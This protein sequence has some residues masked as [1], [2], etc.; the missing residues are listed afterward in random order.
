MAETVNVGFIG[1]GGNARGHMTNVTK[2]GTGPERGSQGTKIVGVCDVVADLAQKAA[3]DFGATAYTDHRALLDRKDLH[4]VYISIP[5]F[6][7]G[8]PEM[9]TIE[10]GLPF[11]VEKPVALNLETARAIEKAVQAR[12]L[13]TCVGYQLRYTG[14]ADAAR[15]ILAGKTVSM[16]IGKYWCGTGR[17]PADRWTRQMAK[18]GGQL[19]EQA[20]HTI[21]MMRY[22][23]GE[24][25]EVLACQ[26]SRI[27]H[28]ID[29]P[30]TNVVALKFA[31][32]AL[33]SLTTSWAFDPRDW[34][35]ANILDILYDANLLHW[36]GAKVTHTRDAKTTEE[37]RPGQQIDAVFIEAVRTG[38]RSLIRSDY[39]DGI[40]SMAVSLAANES[41]RTHTFLKVT[42]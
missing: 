31:S 38:N 12:D 32:G 11:L 42:A 2:A 20:T 37:T 13:M 22:L 26:A 39:S 36:T 14:S 24:V 30:D 21:D 15:E 19:L 40:K 27:L 41:A 35:N 3:K 33:G 6:A 28:E 18:S 5:V 25:T 34:S 8:K 23:L 10:R 7:H 4:A 16:V 9:D 29:C 1:C 17:G